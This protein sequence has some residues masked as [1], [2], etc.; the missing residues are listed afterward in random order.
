MIQEKQKSKPKSLLGKLVEF[1]SLALDNK[2]QELSKSAWGDPLRGVPY[3]KALDT[4]PDKGYAQYGW[5]PKYSLIPDQTKLL[6]YIR[7]PIVA[8][9]VQTRINQ[10]AEFSRPQKDKY[11]SGFCFELKNQADAEDYDLDTL[12]EEKSLLEKFVLNCGL[13]D[14]EREEAEEIMDFETFLR[15]SVK[16]RLIYDS[17]CVE[18]IPTKKQELTG[19]KSLH[20][21]LPVSAATIR[22]ASKNIDPGF[23]NDSDIGNNVSD[24]S[25]GVKREYDRTRHLEGDYKYV[26]VVGGQIRRGFTKDEIIVRF[27]NPVNDFFT[28]GYSVGELD[29]LINILTT[30]LN[31]DRHNKQIF[32]NGVTAPGIINLKGEIDEEMLE[33][34]RR[35]Y[36]A[37]GIGPDAMLRTPVINNPEGVEF[38]KM[39]MQEQDMTYRAL[40]DYLIKVICAVYQIAPE[41]INF[42]SSTK[43][44][45]GS[46]SGQNYNNIERRLKISRDRG[47]R[48]I[49]RFLE[50]IINQ[51]I[52]PY[53]KNDWDW[54]EKYQFK[55]V[56][57]DIES[58]KEELERQEKEVKTFKTIN[59]IRTEHDLDPLPGAVGDII[60]DAQFMQVYMAT[61]KEVQKAQQ[62]A[63]QAMMGSGFGEEL[64][65]GEEEIGGEGIEEQ[66]MDQPPMLD[67]EEQ[68]ELPFAK[69]TKK[70]KEAIDRM[71]KIAVYKKKGK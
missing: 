4:D 40:A 6:V 57:L 16:D 69:S 7:D 53:L 56:G 50:N 19:E 70:Q 14:E 66:D 64:P 13:M 12:K 17:C 18:R 42:S 20:H 47:L 3:R 39:S 33:A 41:E 26:Q 15:L 29:L 35:A 24:L 67:E 11:T 1:S 31:L 21:F 23:V 51:E 28:N 58:K 9:V 45:D 62:E 43:G 2:I 32:E 38:I 71:I 59:E 27:G 5:K 55:F 54:V 49:L 48:P 25:E 30:H 61:N 52:L 8:S 63:Q 65:F 36:Y 60:L 10:V 46:N 22:F 68:G 44:G 37:Q 34:F